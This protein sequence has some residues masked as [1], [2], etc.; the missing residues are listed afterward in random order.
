MAVAGVIL[1]GF[2][3]FASEVQG[4]VITASLIGLGLLFMSPFPIALFLEWAKKQ[5]AD[6]KASS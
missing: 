1:L 2:S 5:S 3:E 4:M 6:D